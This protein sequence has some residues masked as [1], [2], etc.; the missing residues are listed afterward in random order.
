MARF[1]SKLVPGDLLAG[2]YR[3]EQLI[4]QGGMSRVYLAE[5]IKLPG[6]TWAVKECLNVPGAPVS[7]AKEVKLLITLNHHRLPRIVDFIDPDRDGHSYIVMDYIQGVPLDQFIRAREGRLPLELIIRFGLQIA[8]GLRYLHRHEPPVIHRDVKPAN[9]LVDDKGELRFVDFGIARTYSARKTEDTVQLGT[10]G[11]AA[12]EQYG[13]RQSDART[14]LYSLGAVLLYMGTGGRHTVWTSDAAAAL[15]EHGRERLRP[16]VSKL[17]QV[18]PE[19]RF[20]SAEAVSEALALLLRGLS[21]ATSANSGSNARMAEVVAYNGRPALVSVIAASA[22][23]GAT[24]TAIALAHTLAR[25]MK[26]V[27]VVEMDPKSS[28]FVR[29]AQLLEGDEY[30]VDLN[31][32]GRF[33]IGQVVY[34]KLT[35]RAD[36][37]S[38][39]SEGFG[40]IICDLG[41]ARSKELLEEFRRADLSIVVGAGAEW[42]YGELERFVEAFNVKGQIPVSWRICVPFASAASLRRIRRE[43]H[44]KSVYALPADPNPFDPGPSISAA[45]Q[46]VCEHLLMKSKRPGLRLRMKAKP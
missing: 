11:F 43:L 2:R 37:L 45:L 9:L 16:I 41:T 29:L 42:R 10:V 13:D 12:P 38:M 14:D 8:E 15:R 1:V 22:G 6:K 34:A 31:K 26:R 25:S 21:D 18:R 36:Y 46:E 35:S 5:D 28:A 39:L 40:C 20:A 30:A 24:H 23:A 3:I 19:D 32:R 17:L 33:H 7:V 27:A 4:G 44:F